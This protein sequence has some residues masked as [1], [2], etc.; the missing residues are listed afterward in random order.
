[1]PRPAA[2]WPRKSDGYWYVTL[3]GKKTKL[4]KD[5]AEAQK[6]FHRLMADDPPRQPQG[7]ITV[8]KLCDSYL[9][10]T[11][12]GKGDR[13]HA[14]QVIHFKKFCQQFGHRDAAGL[15][16]HEVNDWLATLDTWGNATRALCISYIK[17][18]FN[19]GAEEGRFSVSPLLKLRR[20]STGRR[21]AVLTDTQRESILGAV[22][23]AFRDFLELL[24]ATGCRPFS[25]AAK[26][27][28]GM[29]DF[30][31]SRAVLSEHKNAKKGKA[32]VIYF[33]AAILPRLRE[34]AAAHPTGPIFRNRLGL[35]WSADCA[36]RYFR[37]ACKTLGIEGVTLY[38]LRHTWISEAIAGGIPAETVATLA[39]NTPQVIH[40][41]YLQLDKMA[42]VL[43]AAAEKAA[44]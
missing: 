17:A 32:R 26:L 24:I 15:K 21:D 34:L 27:T 44:K 8:R 28:A 25:E 20:R 14:N 41:N 31:K 13:S 18:A 43:R 29:V 19:F 1:M 40:K 5:K 10:R 36:A 37:R 33:P 12:E 30:G 11:R 7:G 39:G 16:P 2:I 38:N 9:D 6:M 23:P 35:P 42:D 4:A 22:S 3:N